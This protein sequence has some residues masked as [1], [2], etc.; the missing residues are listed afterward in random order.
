MTEV[1]YS[2]GEEQAAI[3]EY[4]GDYRGRFLDVGAYDFKAF[5]NVR[6]LAERGWGGVLV[7]PD[8]QAF[9]CLLANCPP[10]AFPNVRAL[11]AAVMPEPGLVDFSL[12]SAVSTA[13]AA[14]RA[15]WASAV[16]Y[17]E[18]TVYAITPRK[19]LERFPP[20]YDLFSIDIEGNNLSVLEHFPLREMS[21]QCLCVEHDG[22]QERIRELAAE[23]GL[24]REIYHSA[25]NLIVCR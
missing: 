16:D 5:S 18:I 3:L 22:K 23:A 6:A 25:E 4:F 20:P 10:A 2:Q 9:A 24:E 8:P 12:A 15:K 17:R 21:L 19:L 14:H 11:C 13:N 1:S 7:E